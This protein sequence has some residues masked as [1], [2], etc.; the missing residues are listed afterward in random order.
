MQSKS[1]IAAVAITVS[2][3]LSGA[4]YAATPASLATTASIDGVVKVGD[5]K[6]VTWEATNF[7]KGAFVNINLIR[8]TGDSPQTYE[9]VRQVA[10]YTVN[11]GQEV[12][13]VTKADLGDNLYLE[14]GC[15]GSTRFKDGCIA[16]MGQ[17]QFAVSTSFGNNLANAFSAFLEAI[18]LGNN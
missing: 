1:I 12:W 3:L 14:V 18:G 15:A 7:P 6:L 8:K 11:D 10:Q 16:S 17:T 2:L 9:L 4:A 13:Q 5:Q